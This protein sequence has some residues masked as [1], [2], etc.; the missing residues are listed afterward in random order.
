MRSPSAS[1][2]ANRGGTLNRPRAPRD[3]HAPLAR[4]AAGEVVI[5]PVELGAPVLVLG[6]VASVVVA[7]LVTRWALHM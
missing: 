3:R 7:V 1:R 6:V 2:Q 5:V 4:M